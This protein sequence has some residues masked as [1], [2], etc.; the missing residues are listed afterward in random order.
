MLGEFGGRSPGTMQR[1][2]QMFSVRA[3]IRSGF[4]I[5]VAVLA[6]AVCAVAGSA[7][8]ATIDTIA[9]QAILVDAITNT[10]LFEKNADQKMPTS[11]MSKV[12]T[13]YMVFEALRDKRLKMDDTLPVSER[14]WRTQGSKMFVELGNRIKVED[15]IRGMIIQSGNDASIVLAEGLGGSEDAFAKKMTERAHEIGMKDSNFVNA[16]GWPDDNHYSTCRDLATLARALILTFPE[17]YHYD[18]ERDFTYHG[19]K[20]GNRNPLLYRNMGVDGLKT[21]H[22]EIAGYGLIASAQRDGRRLILVVNGLP[23]MQAR[24]DEPARLIE[25]G[26]REF[27]A[28]TL[29]K[30]GESVDSL[31]V[32]LGQA[33]T[34]AAVTGGGLTVTM[35]QEERRGLKVTLQAQVPVPAPIVKG[36]TIGKLVITA[37]GFITREVPLV[38]AEDVARLGFFGRLGAAARH[39]LFGS[40]IQ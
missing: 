10:V 30:P 2:F 7:G 18:A 20:Q 5:A 22:T 21:G 24:A 35:A 34:V 11:S 19:I 9:R 38:A 15:L 40:P 26:F 29:L 39:A 3:L 16:T 36:Q 14:A 32:W 33:P 27:S 8:A 31:P 13:A 1:D 12:M 6:V 28:Y 17:Y 37:P 4:G 23:S 25:W